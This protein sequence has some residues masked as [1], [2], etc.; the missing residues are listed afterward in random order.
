MIDNRF[1]QMATTS[2][3]IFWKFSMKN[4]GKFVLRK[5]GPHRWPIKHKL[6]GIFEKQNK[7]GENANEKFV[8]IQH[9]DLHM[10]WGVV[11]SHWTMQ[12][13]AFSL[14]KKNHHHLMFQEELHN[15]W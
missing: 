4:R 10:F 7:N 11:R 14:L 3:W 1:F 12:F 5:F 6:P 13:S 8:I 2:F 9:L 15:K